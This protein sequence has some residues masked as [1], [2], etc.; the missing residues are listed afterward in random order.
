MKRPCIRNLLVPIDFS[1]MSINAIKTARQLAQRF[2]ASIHLAHVRQFD[3]T[4]AFAAPAPPLVPFSF[5]SYE[6][7]GEKRVLKK[8]N[9]LACEYGV[10]SARRPPVRR[11]FRE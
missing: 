7:D 8:L 3:Y 11:W 9:A 5:M 1:E 2:A 4:A 10:S 6:Q